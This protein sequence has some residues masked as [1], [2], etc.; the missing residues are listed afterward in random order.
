MKTVPSLSLH[1][2]SLNF[3]SN[4]HGIGFLAWKEGW[5]LLIYWQCSKVDD[6]NVYGYQELG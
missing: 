1:H 6:L 4:C 2:V 5:V 3:N